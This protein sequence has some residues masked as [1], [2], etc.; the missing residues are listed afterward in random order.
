M[1]YV[2]S[3][4]AGWLVVE[5]SMIAV[6]TT[7]YGILNSNPQIPNSWDDLEFLDGFPV[8]MHECSFYFH[9]RDSASQ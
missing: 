8:I 9:C 3:D 5:A 7:E 1:Y 6:D 4:L 2:I